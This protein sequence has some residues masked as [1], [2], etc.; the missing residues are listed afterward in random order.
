MRIAALGCVLVG[1]LLGAA[2]V[3]AQE[4]VADSITQFLH[5]SDSRAMGWELDDGSSLVIH[6]EKAADGSIVK[7]TSAVITQADGETVQIVFD[8][9]SSEAAFSRADSQISLYDLDES[10]LGVEFRQSADNDAAVVG[11]NKLDGEISHQYDCRVDPVEEPAS[12]N[13]GSGSFLRMNQNACPGTSPPNTSPAYIQVDQCGQ[14]VTNAYTEMMVKALGEFPLGVLNSEAQVL[15]CHEGGGRYRFDI[16]VGT[17]A[18]LE[19]N[20]AACQGV[21]DGYELM[22]FGNSSLLPDSVKAQI[23]A[24]LTT[25]GVGAAICVTALAAW[26]ISCDA[27]EA[28]GSL[29]T[30]I[31]HLLENISG[32][33]DYLLTPS[34]FIPEGGNRE[35]EWLGGLPK[36]E[37]AQ[38]PFPDTPDEWVL[39]GDDGYACSIQVF[40]YEHGE[41][42]NSYWWT[43]SDRHTGTSPG[44]W[45]ES[46]STFSFQAEPSPT[47]VLNVSTSDI[48]PNHNWY[49]S[50][51]REYGQKLYYKYFIQRKDGG[52]NGGEGPI[53]VTVAYSLHAG[54]TAGSNRGVSASSS[55]T[56]RDK[57][58][59]SNETNSDSS[60]VSASCFSDVEGG[61]CNDADSDSGTLYF[62]IEQDLPGG[63]G[64]DVV[65]QLATGG[66][67]CKATYE[68]YDNYLQSPV[69]LTAW[70]DPV[71]EI[72]PAWEHADQFEV[73][74]PWASEC[75]DNYDN[76]GDGLVDLDDL[77][78]ASYDD[79]SESPICAASLPISEVDSD[80]DGLTASEEAVAGTDPAL[81]DTDG[82]G[83]SD[84]IEVNFGGDPLDDSAWPGWNAVPALS[85]RI[86]LLL[87]GVLLTLG[88]AFLG[89]RRRTH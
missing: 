4:I 55:I 69:S 70:A 45:S 83:Y 80:G 50:C 31:A 66:S 19:I 61:S 8:A 68:P 9:S 75:S 11:A 42:L 62:E 77:D 74:E 72:D 63:V 23:C 1:V 34:A 58:S 82:D 36:V 81:P 37:Y 79:T 14:A 59:T 16:P 18:N 56:A 22:C 10:T 20:L 46:E 88:V 87:L 40:S 54:V 5:P 32:D 41:T 15:G 64:G 12:S 25:T 76:D 28:A 26:S 39:E 52:A 73:I 7:V 13:L 29:C 65:I 89:L 27:L 85:P 43:D 60:V 6:A 86:Q 57:V 33:N 44:R 30:S 21:V 47:I 51:P 24:A 49:W 3:S 2:S 35:A 53:P 17:N 67:I 38:G 48:Q 84:G 78:C 71:I